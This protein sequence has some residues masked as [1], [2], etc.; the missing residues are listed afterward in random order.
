[1]TSENKTIH[2]N[3]YSNCLSDDFDIQSEYLD[4]EVKVDVYW[5]QKMDNKEPMSLLFVNDGQDFQKMPFID[6]FNKLLGDDAL[7]PLMIVG[8]HCSAERRLEYGTAD[9]LDFM[10][11]GSRAK[12]HRKFLLLE[13][14]P[15]IMRQYGLKEVKEISYAGFS[16][17]GLT[18]IDVAWKYP[19]IFTKV[20]VFSGSFW[21][22]LRDL[23][24]GYKE[25]TDRI[26][27]NLIRNGSYHPGLKFFFQTGN[28][29]EKMDRN[30]NGI[31]DSIDDTLSLINELVEKGY[32]RDEDIKY[33]EMPDGRHDVPTW[34]RSFPV[35]LKWGWGIP[36]TKNEK[37]S[38]T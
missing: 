18:A 9:V 3:K 33:F 19:N 35:F 31:I 16:L 34:A 11:R 10:N 29:D 8:I 36:Y 30:N 6:I 13:L 22:R 14:I 37:L 12:Y 25:E 5:P 21:W 2:K 23:H 15:H 4:R 27:H 17:G 1:M 7:H 38:K 28:L 24:D 20:G 26:M 32:S